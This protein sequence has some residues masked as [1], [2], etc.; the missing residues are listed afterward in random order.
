MS[1]LLFVDCC[2]GFPFFTC[3]YSY[4][5]ATCWTR[6]G[7]RIT[8]WCTLFVHDFSWQFYNLSSIRNLHK[9]QTIWKMKQCIQVQF[10]GRKRT[11]VCEHGVHIWWCQTK[12]GIRNKTRASSWETPGTV[13]PGVYPKQT[14]AAGGA[15]T[16]PLIHHLAARTV[17]RSNPCEAQ[18]P[19]QYLNLLV[20]SDVTSRGWNAVSQTQNMDQTRKIEL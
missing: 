4:I 10:P 9:N 6:V 3:W 15:V 12:T 8:G 7:N 5:T 14:V 16:L 20:Y 17:K 19:V 1:F 13:N 18:R 2:R 11:V